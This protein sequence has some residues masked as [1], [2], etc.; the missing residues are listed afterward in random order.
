M[1]PTVLIWVVIIQTS[2][3]VMLVVMVDIFRITVAVLRVASAAIRQMVPVIKPVSKWYLTM[4]V[5]LIRMAVTAAGSL[6]I[7][8]PVRC[9]EV[10]VAVDTVTGV[11]RQRTVGPANGTGNKSPGPIPLL[12]LVSVIMLVEAALVTVIWQG[13]RAVFGLMVARTML[14]AICAPVVTLDI[15]WV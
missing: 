6:M 7:R 13:I 10:V 14:R 5:V 2:V 4:V 1:I 15:F 8:P 3:S 12:R 11:I 9:F